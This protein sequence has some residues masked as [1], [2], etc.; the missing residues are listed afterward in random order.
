MHEL[1]LDIL[2]EYRKIW[3]LYHASNLLSWDI[4][5]YMPIAGAS[6]RGEAFAQLEILQKEIFTKLSALVKK[7]EK[8]ESLDDIERG[9]VRVLSRR[10]KY[11]ER[12]PEEII[13]ELNKV[14]SEGTIEWRIDRKNNEFKRFK[15]Y[16]EK[17]IELNRIIAEKLGYDKHPY[18]ALLDT[19]DEGL[20]VEDLDLIFSRLTSRIPVLL[21][22]DLP[23]NH[24][25]ENIHYKEEEMRKVNEEVIRLLGMPNERFRMDVSTHPF[26]A[27]ISVDDVR[28]TTRYEGF[29]FKRSLYSTIH[30]CG[31]AIYELNL[32]KNLEG[33]PVCSGASSGVHESQSRFWE[34]IIGRS[35]EF[36]EVV[37][38]ILLNLSFLNKY[39]KSEIYTYFNLVKPSF[40]RVD[41]DELT[42]NL[43]IAIRYEIEKR[44]VSNDLNVNE[45]HEFWSELMDK[46]LGIRPR[47]YSDG[48]LQD[49]HWSKGWLGYFPTYTLGNV[50]S[51][52]IWSNMRNLSEYI[53]NKDFTSIK[54]YLKE[55]IHKFGS[56]Y[57]PKDLIKRSFGESYNP[58]YLLKYLEEKYSNF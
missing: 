1:I 31:H 12:I 50:I 7:A 40:I 54:E 13:L 23:S 41:A 33:T 36:V 44:L 18:N 26:T 38:P 22:K 57:A 25:L 34:N 30:E 20:A 55:K 39:S 58:D 51:G 6:A 56:I 5:T 11:Y 8:I 17:V 49:I 16:L 29:D 14:S 46:Y 35:K 53:Y 28:I 4:E 32:D 15:P 52:I 43:H 47:G 21:R 27:G 42:Y 37:Y 19:Y 24:E 10:I 2:K 3:A 48:F 45:I 9:I